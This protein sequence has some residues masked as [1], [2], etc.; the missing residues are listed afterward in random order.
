MRERK[1]DNF[2]LLVFDGVYDPADDSLLLAD[3]LAVKPGDVVLDVGSGTGI[4]SL[5]AMAKGARRVVAIDISPLAAKNTLINAKRNG[6]EDKV[7]IIIGDLLTFLKT[8]SPFD[9]VVFNPPYLPTEDPGN[10]G[11]AWSGGKTGRKVVG[12]FIDM[13]KNHLQSPKKRYQVIFSSLMKPK[14][15]LKHLSAL[16]FKYVI[17]ARKRFFFEEICLVTFSPH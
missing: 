11:L 12:R 15:L 16:G 5:F 1:I 14:K 7:D 6:Y 13:V 17:N 2:S 10:W 3:H 4:I 9:L 8:I